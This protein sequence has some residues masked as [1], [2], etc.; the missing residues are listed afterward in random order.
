MSLKVTFDDEF[1]E[2]QSLLYLIC[3]DITYKNN[4]YF[5]NNGQWYRASQEFI[6]VMTRELDNIECIDP[7]NLGLVE[8]DKTKFAEE[9]DFNKGQHGFVVMDHVHRI[10]ALMTMT[11]YG[12]C[13]SRSFCRD[14]AEIH[15]ESYFA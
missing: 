9:K 13:S 12:T 15:S 1:T 11:R 6:T 8:W 10:I 3:G 7:D 5:L 4:V 2:S 14:F